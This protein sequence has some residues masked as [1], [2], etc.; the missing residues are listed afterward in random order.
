MS[1]LEDLYQ[2]VIKDHSRSPRNFRKMAS[3]NR[4]ADGHNRLCGDKLHLY[5]L[6]EADRIKDVAFQGDGCA[7][8]KASA[9]LMSEM[10]KGKTIAEAEALFHR[11]HDVVTGPAD[12]EPDMSDLDKLVVFHGVRKFPVRVKCATLPWHT[13][14]AALKDDHKPVSTE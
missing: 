11:F 14:Q 6:V 10:L 7:I 1:E 8:S 13:L 4:Q 5:V 2:D 9:S 12:E 3:A